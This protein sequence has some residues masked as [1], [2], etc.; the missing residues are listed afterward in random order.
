[1]PPYNGQIDEGQIDGDLLPASVKIAAQDAVAL[2]PGSIFGAKPLE[3][4]RAQRFFDR[5][6]M[7]GLIVQTFQNLPAETYTAYV[8]QPLRG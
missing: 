2:V 7:R 1:M 5:C 4:C 3:E 8:I 6:G